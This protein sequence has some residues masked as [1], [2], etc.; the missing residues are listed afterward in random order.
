[1]KN[2]LQR[3]TK[4]KEYSKFWATFF[5]NFQDFGAFTREINKTSSPQQKN[6]QKRNFNKD[7]VFDFKRLFI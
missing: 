4:K 5:V 7:C 6:S 1:M 3:S 2:T